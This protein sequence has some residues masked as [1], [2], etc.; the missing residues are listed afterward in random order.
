VEQNPYQSP[1]TPNRRIGSGFAGAMFVII[2]VICWL[3]GLAYA[4]YLIVW[5][6]QGPGMTHLKE[7]PLRFAFISTCGVLFP[8]SGMVTFG[9][10]SWRRSIRLAEAGA[11]L[12]VPFVLLLA[13][14]I[15]DSFQ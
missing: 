2:A 4:G 11:A 6:F 8:A 3:A 12:M 1:E 14:K 9:F 10:A 15:Y 5:T 13:A 7:T